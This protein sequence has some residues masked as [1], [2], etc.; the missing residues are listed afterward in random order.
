MNPEKVLVLVLHNISILLSDNI[1]DDPFDD[2]QPE[3][4][5]YHEPDEGRLLR[6]HIRNIYFF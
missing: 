3:L 1:D 6:D 2:D 5:P 4:T